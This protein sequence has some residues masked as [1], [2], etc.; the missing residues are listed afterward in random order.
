[1][2]RT[3]PT[4]NEEKILYFAHQEKG[5]HVDVQKEKDTTLGKLIKGALQSQLLTVS[6]K[7]GHNIWYKTTPEGANRLAQHQAKYKARTGQSDN[8]P[9]FTEEKVL[10]FASKAKGLHVDS[11]KERGT[12][13]DQVVTD[14]LSKQYL[15]LQRRDGHNRYYTLTAAGESRLRQ[16]QQPDLVAPTLPVTATQQ[17]DATTSEAVNMLFSTATLNAALSTLSEQ[18]IWPVDIEPDEATSALLAT[19]W[20][21][22]QAED[23]AYTYF[24]PAAHAEAALRQYQHTGDIA[25]LL[26]ALPISDVGAVHLPTAFPE[27]LTEYRQAGLAYLT[28]L[29]QTGQLMQPVLDGLN[30]LHWDAYFADRVALRQAV[31][32]VVDLKYILPENSP[33][34][35]ADQSQQLQLLAK[36]FKAR[37]PDLE[38]HQAARLFAEE[39]REFLGRAFSEHESEHMLRYADWQDA[40]PPFVPPDA[41]ETRSAPAVTL[42]SSDRQQENEI[43]TLTR[44]RR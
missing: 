42:S 16:L 10:H 32:E 9:R 22:A 37:C 15:T 14:A 34:H 24:L 25:S 26:Q 44:P 17:H 30:D 7:D 11:Q 31:Q 20:F 40:A 33:Q 28:H 18:G 3:F 13:L 35:L 36:A 39:G 5:L 21:S 19:G 8:S 23:D 4:F 6:K 41:T 43:A 29:V 1:M 27:T 2:K 38:M 12:T